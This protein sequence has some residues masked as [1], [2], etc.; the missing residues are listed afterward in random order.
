MRHFFAAC[1]LL[2]TAALGTVATAQQGHWIQIEAHPTLRAAEDA[3]RGYAARTDGVAGFQLSTGWYVIAIGPY[4]EDEAQDR[5]NGLQAADRVPPDAFVHDGTGYEAQFWPVGANALAAATVSEPVAE[6]APLPE[7]DE[8]VAEARASER[9]LDRA[10]RDALQIALQ[11]EG[12]YT[13]RID[14]AFGPGTRASMAEWQ[15]MMGYEQTGVLTTRQRAELLDRYQAVLDS[16][17]MR[18]VFDEDAGISVDMPTAMVNFSRYEAPFAHY[19]GTGDNGVRVVLISQTGDQNTLFGLYDILQSLEIVPLNGPRERSRNSFVIEGSDGRIESYT[20]AQLVDGA[21]KGF[22][23]IWPVG[24]DKRR[25]MA[26]DEMKASF[27]SLG[28]QALADNAGLDQATQSLDLLS[29]LRIRRPSLSR[30]GFFV[31]GRGMVLTTVEAVENCRRITL[32][33]TYDAELVATDP[34]LGV[35]LLRPV[36]ALAPAKVAAFLTDDARLNT[37]IAV[38]GYP[39]EGRLGA[40]TLTFGKL[41]E[42]TG[43]GGEP[44]LTRLSLN[45]HPGDA[46]GPVYDSGGSVI[47]MLLPKAAAGSMQLPGD[48]RFAADSGALAAFLGENGVT[49]TAIEAPAHM[50]PFD[51]S[52]QAAGMVVLVSCW[53]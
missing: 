35:A 52:G 6:P 8:T 25:R 4:G 34:A 43:L 29:G 41:A 15:E 23:L 11:W 31:D 42:L 13:A 19:E 36:T 7:P 10:Q 50:D 26:L 33:E 40:P 46:G 32:N 20:F 21:V 22:T 44:E 47:G 5:L 45:A 39:F 51:M 27:S 24:D 9:A 17:S 12:L 28:G 14:G 16:L 37:D 49:V 18:T 53:N 30:S 3:V 48:V 1:I 2:V 38:G